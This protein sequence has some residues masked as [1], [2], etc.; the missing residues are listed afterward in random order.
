M[1][2]VRSAASARVAVAENEQL[3]MLE[4]ARERFREL[5]GRR[6]RLREAYDTLREHGQEEETGAAAK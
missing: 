3:K 5:E 6:K 1:Q 4:A 2:E